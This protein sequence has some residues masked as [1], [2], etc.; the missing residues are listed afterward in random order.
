M[1]ADVTS[2]ANAMFGAGSLNA[3]RFIEQA[4]ANAAQQKAKADA[5]Q[6]RNAG[7]S[8]LSQQLGGQ[9]A[10][11]GFSW[12]G[13]KAAD[14]HQSK[15]AGILYDK[16]VRNLSDLGYSKDGK[17]LINKNT[18]QIVPWYK[19]EKMNKNGRAQIGWEAAG[20]GRTNYYVHKDANGNPV[21]APKWKSNAPGGVGGFLLKAAPAIAGAVGG[22]WA[23]AGVA[24]LTSAASGDKLGQILKNAGIAGGTAYLGGKANLATQGALKGLDP[25]VIKGLGSA[26]QGFTQSGLSG[27]ATGNFSLKDALAS[28]LSAGAAGGIQSLLSPQSLPA[29]QAGPAAPGMVNTGSPTLDRALTSTAAGT[30]GRV[31]AGQGV[32]DALVNSL[33]RAGSQ[34]AGSQVASMMPETGTTWLDSLLKNAGGNLASTAFTGL[35]NELTGGAGGTQTAAS[36]YGANPNMMPMQTASTGQDNMAKFMELANYGQDQQTA[37][38][39]AS[40]GFDV[41]QAFE[42]TK[43]AQKQQSLADFLQSGRQSFA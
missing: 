17:N 10:Q 42:P 43:Y 14:F 30:A 11:Y 7:I 16:G 25:S 26:A 27:A 4:T 12:K 19:D 23:A 37:Q 31:V 15:M 33:T 35:L 24:G 8:A 21:F 41:S 29:G 5:A 9:A 39:P 13:N 38:A 32:E 40:S 28:G 1:M 18:G 2:L 6:A 36:M 20:K 3:K 22:P 34:A